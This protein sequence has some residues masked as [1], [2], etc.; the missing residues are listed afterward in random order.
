MGVV[1]LVSISTPLSSSISDYIISILTLFSHLCDTS[2]GF[3]PTP[4]FAL[5]Q[6][7]IASCCLFYLTFYPLA[8]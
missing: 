3:I 2:F 8:T 5:Y 1:I 4:T 6:S 7:N